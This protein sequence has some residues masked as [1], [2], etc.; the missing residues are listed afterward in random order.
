MK[1]DVVVFFWEIFETSEPLNM[2]NKQDEER[3]AQEQKQCALQQLPLLGK[4][5]R[6]SCIFVSMLNAQVLRRNK[7]E[8]ESNTQCDSATV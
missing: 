4:D 3:C 2:L 7:F 8:N 6:Q 5:Q 1:D